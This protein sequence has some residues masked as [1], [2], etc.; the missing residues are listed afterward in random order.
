MK[1]NFVVLNDLP[2]NDAIIRFKVS[3]IIVHGFY[4]YTTFPKESNKKLGEEE[5][6]FPFQMRKDSQLE[7]YFPSDKPTG[8]NIVPLRKPAIVRK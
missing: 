8:W 4:Y 5:W 7:L 2:H 1:M 6:N 3:M